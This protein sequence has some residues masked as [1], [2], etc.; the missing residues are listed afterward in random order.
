MGG[1][2]IAVAAGAIRPITV[3]ATSGILSILPGDGY[4]MGWSFRDVTS[5]KGFA[6]D[7]S[8]T[9]PGAG[10]VIATSAATIFGNY[11][12]SWTVSLEG[13]AAAADVDNFGL[14]VGATLIATSVNPGAQGNYPQPVVEEMVAFGQTVSIQA[15]G[16]GTAGVEYTADMFGE[17]Q[18]T[19]SSY[20]RFN[21]GTRIVGEGSMQSGES[22]SQ[23]FGS[24][25]LKIY[26]GLTLDVLQGSI[27]GSVNM[28]YNKAY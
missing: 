19:L 21:D 8:V 1:F 26:T 24:F 22:T 20:F 10:T 28:M 7:G 27:E 11:Q 16:A 12:I 2:D 25:G 13:A 17:T 18:G 23:N 3:P 5:T 15:I 14:Y 9:A 6:A 4:L